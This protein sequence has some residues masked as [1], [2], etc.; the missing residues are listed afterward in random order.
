MT[1]NVKKIIR[2][3]FS[4]GRKFRKPLEAGEANIDETENLKTL[5]VVG[6]TLEVLRTTTIQI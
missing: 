2:A 4:K 3:Y 6:E 5:K 1:H